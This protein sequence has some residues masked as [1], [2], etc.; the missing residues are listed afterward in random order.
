MGI[1]PAQFLEMQVRV[2]N[3]KPPAPPSDAEKNELKLHDK[4]INYCN[5]RWPKW[6]YIHANP[7]VRSTIQVGAQDFTIFA[8]R[9]RVFCIE[10]KSKTGKRDQDQQIWAKEMEMLGFTVHLV[11]SME[12][13]FNLVESNDEREP[14]TTRPC[15]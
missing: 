3:Q 13:F 6:K 15:G 2:A 4:I 9:A 1:S 10:C 5:S 14:I 12:E 8:D 11:R 7:S